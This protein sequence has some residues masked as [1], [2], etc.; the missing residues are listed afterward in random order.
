LD[1][2][3][4]L[5]ATMSYQNKIED[6][7]RLKNYLKQL[8]LKKF[9]NKNYFKNNNI[10]SI[11]N[12]S[13]GEKQRIGFIRSIIREPNLLLLD[14]PTAFLDKKNEKRIFDFLNII[15]QDKIIVVTSH[16][17]EQ[18]KYFDCIINL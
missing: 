6:I 4:E 7:L 2:N 10:S 11:K 9:L 17:K 8:N 5:N 15:K 16:K 13:G 3:I 12:M 1:E 14:E 18:K